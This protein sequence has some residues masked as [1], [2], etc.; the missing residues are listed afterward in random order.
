M[1][2]KILLSFIVIFFSQYVLT[3][4]FC[5]YNYKNDFAS[6]LLKEWQDQFKWER[7]VSLKDID[8]NR[9]FTDNIRD[10]FYPSESGADGLW[11]NI[12]RKTIRSIMVGILIFFMVRAW[13][14]FVMDAADEWE[15]KKSQMNLLY[16]VLGAAIIFTVTRLLWDALKL[17]S[18]EWVV[19]Q[20]GNPSKW[21]SLLD[22][23]ETNIFVVVL[24]FLKWFAFFLAI[25]MLM[26]YGY[27]MMIAFDKDDKID[28]AKT[29]IVNVILALL[30]I[31]IIDFLY[32]IAQQ[33]DFTS[34]ANELILVVAKFLWYIFGILIVLVIIY[35]A[36]QFI[37]WWEEWFKKWLNFLKNLVIVALVIF[38][39]LLVLYQVFHDLV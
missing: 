27:Q 1:I 14:R 18:I 37:T 30:F 9:S 32:Y 11:Q 23:A 35:I 34:K 12:L 8:D 10:L 6:K 21:V 19:N 17:W 24:W 13:F 38:L 22:R 25:I 3:L 5:E 7:M 15:V 36:F 4:N 26:Y 29:G 28:A 39:F 16:I 33:S 2:K 20:G 31:K